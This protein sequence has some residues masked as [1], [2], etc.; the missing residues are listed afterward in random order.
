MLAEG[1]RNGFDQQVGNR[2][3]GLPVFLELTAKLLRRLHI[4]LSRQIE[5]RH[6]CFALHRSPSDGFPH[7]G[8]GLIGSNRHG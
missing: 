7:L 5:V 2:R 3:M 1:K 8:Q 4:D 6:R